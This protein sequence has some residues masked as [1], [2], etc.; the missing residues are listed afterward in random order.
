MTNWWQS[1]RDRGSQIKENNNS[2]GLAPT[3]VFPK[4]KALHSSMEKQVWGQDA[5]LVIIVLFVGISAFGLGRLSSFEES[6]PAI[7]MTQQASVS[8]S[9]INIGGQ[10]V[11][12]RKGSKYHFP[13]CSGSKSMKESNKIWFDSEEDAR[14]SGYTPA[15]NCKGLR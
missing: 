12:S 5:M 3:P 2:W 8:D 11:A 9:P 7:R 14:Q 13:W 15:K 1:I 6:R 4:R 10:L